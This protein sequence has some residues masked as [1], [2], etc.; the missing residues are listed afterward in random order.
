MAEKIAASRNLV[1]GREG[2]AAH[3]RIEGNGQTPH[4]TKFIVHWSGKG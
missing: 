1:V 2:N 4:T 3:P